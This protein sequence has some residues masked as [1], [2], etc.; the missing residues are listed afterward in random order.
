MI[1]LTVARHAD[2]MTEQGMRGEVW[3]KEQLEKTIA[4]LKKY[5]KTPAQKKLAKIAFVDSADWHYWC[6][7][8]SDKYIAMVRYALRRV[9]KGQ[10]LAVLCNIDSKHAA[11]KTPFLR[12]LEFLAA[13]NDYKNWVEVEVRARRY[14]MPVE[15]AMRRVKKY[16]GVLTAE[17]A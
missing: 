16:H 9:G 5:T 17:F 1:R 10:D 3:A 11:W 8:I 14:F 2:F 12:Y 15:E 4:M 7:Y 13:K 6:N